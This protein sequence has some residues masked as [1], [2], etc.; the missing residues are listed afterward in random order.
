MR[1]LVEPA[2]SNHC[3]KCSGELRL[4]QVIDQ[5]DNQNISAETFVC[6]DC[7]HEQSYTVRHD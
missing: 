7:A 1:P 4:Q 6:G 2:P 3:E 5:P